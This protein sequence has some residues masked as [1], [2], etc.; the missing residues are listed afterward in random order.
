MIIIVTVTVI[1]DDFCELSHQINQFIV[2]TLP[3]HPHPKKGDD[4]TF[5]M[6]PVYLSRLIFV[7]GYE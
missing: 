2:M 6:V 1:I 4:H 5:P 3:S 7:T